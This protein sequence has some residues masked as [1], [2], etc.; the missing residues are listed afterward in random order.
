MRFFKIPIII[1]R[2]FPNIIWRIPQGS[3]EIFLTFD[4]GPDEIFTSQILQILQKEQVSSTFFILGEKAKTSPAI[5]KSIKDFGHTIGLHSFLHQSLIYKSKKNIF[6]QLYT[7]KNYIEQ[8]TGEPVKYFRP[9]FGRFSPAVNNVCRQI[10]LQMV[11]WNVM[12][13]DF[14][15]NIS[16]S[17][18][19]NLVETKTCG[20]D[21]IVFHDGHKN[22]GR[23]VNI[24][25]PIINILKNKGFHLTS[26]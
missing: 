2:I 1:Q 8:L 5:V 17:Y 3:N 4:D 7:S 11:L 25:E 23:T 21:I 9:P 13:Y 26:I 20:G 15:L 6:D 12:S 14:D 19:F 24:L 16:D 22:S 10:D 18:I